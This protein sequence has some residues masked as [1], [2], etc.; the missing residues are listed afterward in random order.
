MGQLQKRDPGAEGARIGG[1]ERLNGRACRHV[2]A[3][4]H[5]SRFHENK[6]RGIN[7]NL[8]LPRLAWRLSLYLGL[9]AG[10]GRVQSP[11]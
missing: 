1:V 2:Q 3:K 5:I 8:L 10:H 6:G 11:D 4:G 9:R 7:S